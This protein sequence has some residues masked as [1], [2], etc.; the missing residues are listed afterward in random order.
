M[1]WLPTQLLPAAQLPQLWVPPQPL[2]TVPQVSPAQATALTEGLQQV[3]ALQVGAVAGQVPQD[4]Q[5]FGDVPQ[6]RAPQS[7]VQATQA[8]ALH[9]VPAAQVPQLMLLPQPVGAV[10]HTCVPHASAFVFGVQHRPDTQG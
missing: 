1:H 3:P 7:G 4:P 9:V 10:P 8:P 2:G 6:V 5:P